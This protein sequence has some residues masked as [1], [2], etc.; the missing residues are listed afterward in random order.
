MGFPRSPSSTS[1]AGPLSIPASTYALRSF[2][3]APPSEEAADPMRVASFRAPR[4][5][6]VRY[7]GPGVADLVAAQVQNFERVLPERTFCIFS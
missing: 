3:E 6:S 5:A 1:G 4:L 7:R 2:P